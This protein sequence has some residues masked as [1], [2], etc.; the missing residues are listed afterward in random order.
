MPHTISASQLA[1]DLQ[2][3]D[4]SD[5][6]A[7]PHAVQEIIRLAVKALTAA[8]NCPVREV[9]GPR[10]VSL[11]DN[12][13]DLGYP[14]ATVTR[15]RRY[16]RYVDDQHVLRSHTSALVPPALRRLSGS[17]LHDVVL[18]CPG[19][20][21][22][23]D[24]IDGLHTGTP[25]QLDLWRIRQ[26][27]LTGPLTDADLDEMLEL[28]MT[29]LL[30]GRP[31]RWEPRE[32][33][34]TLRGRQVDVR[35]DDGWVE[36]WE[37]GLAHPDL[38]VRTAGPGWSGLALG[39]GLDRLLMIRK[40]IPDIRLLRSTDPR[41]AGQMLDLAPYQPVSVLPAV[42]RDLSLAVGPDDDIETLGD[43]LR[44][45]LGPQAE[46]IESVTLLS[47]TR[48]DQLP[49]P[50]RDRLGIAEGQKNVLVRLMIRPH[51]RTLTD[52]EANRLRDVAYSAL[53]QG[54]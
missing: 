43:R 2:L 54:R 24:A 35:H 47:E 29:A 14:A 33:P 52:A 15:D 50:A 13:D 48:P 51:D 10:V 27:P 8:W 11:A 20:A 44:L 4:L 49:Q 26:G 28:L 42:A 17:A 32:H 31:W 18:A 6:A 40:G 39:M 19:I 45:A 1:H 12:Y 25:H 22:R 37:C 36:V 38:L 16:T 53:H 5:P 34:Y 9:R 7:G 23:R 3:R 41:V 30:P 46:L 21:Y